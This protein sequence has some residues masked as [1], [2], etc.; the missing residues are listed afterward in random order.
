MISSTKLAKLVLE[1]SLPSWILTS[2]DL[3]LVSRARYRRGWS[4][5]GTSLATCCEVY[6]I[7]RQYADTRYVG[8]EAGVVVGGS[9]YIC[10]LSLCCRSGNWIPSTVFHNN[11]RVCTLPMQYNY[12]YFPAWPFTL[13]PPSRKAWWHAPWLARA[14]AEQYSQ[15]VVTYNKSPVE[16]F[17][18]GIKNLDRWKLSLI[19][20]H[21]L[22][23][24]GSKDKDIATCPQ[25]LT[26]CLDQS[27]RVHLDPLISS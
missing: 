3:A 9:G 12:R 13:L 16:T 2:T 20:D 15:G 4:A 7:R 11:C 21:S 23:R 25:Y 19:T 8:G 10:P 18:T 1:P 17:A 14:H 22:P 5:C 24:Q 6:S 26:K 27:L